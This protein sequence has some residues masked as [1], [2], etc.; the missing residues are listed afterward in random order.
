MNTYIFYIETGFYELGL[1]N[2]IDAVENA[3]CNQD[4]IKI[5]DDFGNVIWEKESY[6]VQTLCK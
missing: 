3:K 4:T 5:T 2:D 1:L 6:V